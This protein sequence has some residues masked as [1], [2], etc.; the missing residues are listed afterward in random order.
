MNSIYSTPISVAQDSELRKFVRRVAVRESKLLDSIGSAQV[1]Q[2]V[3]KKVM[4][5][6]HSQAQNIEEE[7]GI[8]SSL[9][10]EEAKQ[11]LED[12]LAEVRGS[13]K[14]R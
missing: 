6:L 12:V 2:E 11:H 3:I 9:T 10:D 8:E 1:E 13:K 7:T 5:L 4:P 14:S